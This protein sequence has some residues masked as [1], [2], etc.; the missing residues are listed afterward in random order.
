MGNVGDKILPEELVVL[1]LLGH[2]VE[3]ALQLV[4]LL[5]PVPDAQL[6]VEIPGGDLLGGAV[7]LPDGVGRRAGGDHDGGH[8]D[9]I[10]DDHQQ[11]VPDHQTG[12]QVVHLIPGEE[13]AVPREPEEDQRDGG[14]GDH[15]GGEEDR[16]SGADAFHSRTTAL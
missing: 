1:Q 5:H 12:E 8:D 14:A 13:D 16:Q 7:E 9:D 2:A 11:N 6:H 15:D 3:V 4:E 10:G